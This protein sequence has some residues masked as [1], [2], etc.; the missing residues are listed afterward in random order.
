MVDWVTILFSASLSVSLSAIASMGLTE[1]R[2]K[3]EQSVEEANEI[4]EW[5]TKSAEYAADVRRSWQ[6]I[7]D[8]PEGQAA[9]LSELQ[10]EMSLLEGQISRHASEGEQLGV[11]EEPIEALDRLADE[12]RRTAEHRTHINSY[13]EFEE[14]RQETLDAVEELEEVLER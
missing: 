3:R 12:C 13:P 2:L 6:R 14:F 8:T 1:Y 9:N 5:Y 4:D 10:S 7:F 11:D